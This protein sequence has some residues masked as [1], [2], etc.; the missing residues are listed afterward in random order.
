MNETLL[1]YINTAIGKTFK[2]KDRFKYNGRVSMRDFYDGKI[3]AYREIENLLLIH[4][5]G[6]NK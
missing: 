6:E 5:S 4:I 3:E 1:S 2:S